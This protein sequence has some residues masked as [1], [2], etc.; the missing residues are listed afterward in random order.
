MCVLN[1]KPLQEESVLLPAI[2]GR[3][4]A[5]L[6]LAKILDAGI[7]GRSICLGLLK[8]AHSRED[9]LPSQILLTREVKAFDFALAA[10]LLE[11]IHME[12]S[13]KLYRFRNVL[14]P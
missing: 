9:G 14:N 2:L 12:L 13:A 4:I 5:T 1:R 10:C 6:V 8:L 7:V 11:E 3:G